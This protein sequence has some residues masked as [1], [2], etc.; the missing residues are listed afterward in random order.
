[1]FTHISRRLIAAGLLATILAGCAIQPGQPTAS[2]PTPIPTTGSTGSAP[3]PAARPTIVGQPTPVPP[4]VASQPTSA[5][6][7]PTTPP[8]AQPTAQPTRRP[9]FSFDPREGLAGGQIYLS[10]WDFAPGGDIAVRLGLPQPIGEALTSARADTAGRWDSSLI[11]PSHLPSGELVPA[12]Q[13]FLVVMD[14]NTNA[15]LASAPFQYHVLG[16]PTLDQASQTVGDFLHAVGT[17]EAWGYL[18]SGMDDDRPLEERLGLRH[19]WVTYEVGA[20]LDR[21]SEVLFVPAVLISDIGRHHYVFTLVVERGQWKINGAGWERDEQSPQEAARQPDPYDYSNMG[22]V[23]LR[24]LRPARSNT[25]IVVGAVAVAGT[26]AAAYALPY[27]EG[28]QF[29]YLRQAPGAGWEVTFVTSEPTLDVLASAGIPGSLLVDGDVPSIFDTLIAYYNSPAYGGADGWLSVDGF[30]GSYARA[31]L[32]RDVDGD[33][34]IYLRRAVG[35]WERLI[36]GQMFA[37]EA[38]DG[39]GIPA[40]LR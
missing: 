33:L 18:A 31:T 17:P 34:T 9:T 13:I 5:P 30:E 29:F 38:L 10:G 14:A 40:G 25:P 8:I 26:Y 15:V 2:Q 24:H 19:H 39:L 23:M 11:I 36:D 35:G 3:T 7:T 22:T 21:P 1:M 32:H 12:G 6:A 37:P 20:P 27:G 16:G 28:K 4:T